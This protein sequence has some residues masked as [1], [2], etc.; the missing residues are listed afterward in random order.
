MRRATSVDD[1]PPAP[2]SADG[3]GGRDEAAR[4]GLGSVA[5]PWRGGVAETDVGTR[6]GGTAEPG[7]GRASAVD[8]RSSVAHSR[9]LARRTRL[10]S[11]VQC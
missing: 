1:G 6:P 4:I 11:W 7:A 5:T 10:V 2:V 9:P 3:R 8:V